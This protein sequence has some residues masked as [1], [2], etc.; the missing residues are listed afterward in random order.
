[1]IAVSST[2]SCST[3]ATWSISVSHAASITRSGCRMNAVPSG[4]VCPRCASV[5]S[6]IA[7]SIVGIDAASSPKT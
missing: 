2:T 6:A 7:S 1:M 3:A 5:A 4:R